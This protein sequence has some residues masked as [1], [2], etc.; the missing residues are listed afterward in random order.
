MFLDL[1]IGIAL[2]L[3]TAAMFGW[4][5]VT[6]FIVGGIA[7]LLLPDVDFILYRL[8]ARRPPQFDYLHRDIFHKP[9]P[10]IAI[11]SV[12]SFVMGGMSWALLFAIASLMHFL[13][14]T[15]GVGFGIKW[16]WPF[17]SRLI[18]FRHSGLAA[19][20]GYDRVPLICAVPS[21]QVDRY[22]ERQP[23]PR[24]SWIAETYGQWSKTAM[25]EYGALVI[26]LIVGVL[27]YLYVLPRYSS[28]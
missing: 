5:H 3:G 14:D 20:A 16:L 17:S 13:H 12:I 9:I 10:Y 7:F 6:S 15:T 27:V 21:H 24:K 11:G 25:I 22:V 2:G 23:T 18:G 1:A 26:I 8:W 28:G 4:E 19:C